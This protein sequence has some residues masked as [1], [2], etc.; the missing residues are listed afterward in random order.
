MRLGRPG[1]GRHLHAEGRCQRAREFATAALVH[2]P[3]TVGG[4]D[5]PSPHPSPRDGLLLTLE[6]WHAVRDTWPAG[7]RT[8]LAI[9]PGPLMVP[10]FDPG[11]IEHP[12]IPIQIAARLSRSST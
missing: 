7:T 1:R 6:Q 9:T 2:D 12:D 8:G 3:P 10:L 4:E 11:P 5:G